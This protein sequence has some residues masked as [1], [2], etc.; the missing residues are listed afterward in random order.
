MTRRPLAAALLAAVLAG[1]AVP[2]AAEPRVV[3]ALLDQLPREVPHRAPSPL[4]LV[5]FRPEARAALDTTQMAYA[6]QPHQ[7]AYYAHHQWAETPPQM[8]QPLLLRTLEATGAFHAVVTPPASVAA[9]VGLRTEI[10][11][12]VQDHGATP[13]VLRLALRVTLEDPRARTVLGTREISIAEPM[14]RAGPEAGVAAANAAVA[15]VL[16]EVAQFAIDRTP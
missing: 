13:P 5:V 3:T 7:L 1:C 10:L 14:A 6:L 16:R 15:K 8:L 4:T 12:L 9:S 2:P 11:A